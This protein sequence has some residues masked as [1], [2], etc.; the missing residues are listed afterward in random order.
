MLGLDPN[1]KIRYGGSA[2]NTQTARHF[3][4]FMKLVH[5]KEKIQAL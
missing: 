2:S 4:D 5:N 3:F 1:M